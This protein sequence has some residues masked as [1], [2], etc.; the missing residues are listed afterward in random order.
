MKTVLIN[1]CLLVSVSIS[2]QSEVGFLNS[3]GNGEMKQL[4]T[5]LSDQVILSINDNLERVSKRVAIQRI[6]T[7]IKS[8]KILKFK[9]LHNGKAADKQSSYKVARL[10]TQSGTYRIFAYSEG[11]KGRAKIVEVRIDAM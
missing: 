1:I 3:I 4:E 7:F 2:A 8:K 6:R 9:I 10:K 5:Y 11:S